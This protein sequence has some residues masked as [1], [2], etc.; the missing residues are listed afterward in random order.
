MIK[1]QRRPR[2]GRKHLT[3]VIRIVRAEWLD[4]L[5]KGHRKAYAIA[6]CNRAK[7]IF[8]DQLEGHK[9]TRHGHRFLETAA[10][11]VWIRPGRR[12]I[13]QALVAPDAIFE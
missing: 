5:R 8:A 11:T 2:S 7:P 3:N 9:R 6:A 10:A 4:W 13:G 1:V 12:E